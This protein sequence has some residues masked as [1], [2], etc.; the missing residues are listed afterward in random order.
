M[1]AMQ[2]PSLVYNNV[3]FTASSKSSCKEHK[4]NQYVMA[5]HPCHGRSKNSP[6][7][8]LK[9]RTPLWSY[10]IARHNNNSK[11]FVQSTVFRRPEKSWNI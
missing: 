3:K 10:H 5:D 9:K 8:S 11:T 6:V 2:I 4:I 7:M 1:N